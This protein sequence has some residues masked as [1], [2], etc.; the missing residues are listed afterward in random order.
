MGSAGGSALVTLSLLIDQLIGADSRFWFQG[1][2]HHFDEWITDIQRLIKAFLEY[3]FSSL[4]FQVTIYGSC[5][6]PISCRSSND[7]CTQDIYSQFKFYLSFENS[8][9]QDYVTEK[10]FN[11]LNKDIV[12]IVMGNQ[13]I[14]KSLK[15]WKKST[16]FVQ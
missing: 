7:R 12:P 9:C 2:Q 10:L 5:G 4:S 8:V 6:E 16:K 1:F 3:S 14:E 15:N 11:P 13:P